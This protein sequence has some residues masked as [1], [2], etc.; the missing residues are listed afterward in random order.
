M[1]MRLW[2][3]TN[4]LTFLVRTRAL[5]RSGL[6]SCEEDTTLERGE[7]KASFVL[8]QNVVEDRKFGS[9]SVRFGKN[10]MH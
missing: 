6:G 3:V 9:L 1:V 8:R 2:I 10:S 5:T 4:S 7:T